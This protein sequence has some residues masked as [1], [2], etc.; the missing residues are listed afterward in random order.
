MSEAGR[1]ITEYTDAEV[2][3][4][5]EAAEFHMGEA[6]KALDVTRSAL[7]DRVDRTPGLVLLVQDHDEAVIDDAE[8]VIKHDLRAK[9]GP[10]AKFV[11][12]TK[13]K[14]RGWGTAGA[15]DGGTKV[16]VEVRQFAEPSG[17]GNGGKG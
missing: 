8:R 3:E 9:D 5:L 10:T 16:I 13:G 7:K 1:N 14:N 2:A 4:A 17:D 6:A 12:Q 11:A 15:N